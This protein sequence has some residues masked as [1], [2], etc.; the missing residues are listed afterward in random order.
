MPILLRICPSGSAHYL[1]T[2]R[3]KLRNPKEYQQILCTNPPQYAIL[4]SI[5]KRTLVP[6][7]TERKAYD[8]LLDSS[9]AFLLVF[10]VSRAKFGGEKSMLARVI[11]AILGTLVFIVHF[12][13][14]IWFNTEPVTISAAGKA[15]VYAA[16]IVL[17]IL[18]IILTLLSQ[19]PKKENEE[20]TEE[21]ENDT[22]ETA[23]AETNEGTAAK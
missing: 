22:E 13:V 18:M 16:P 21:S 5:N 23:T 10:F 7:Y 2:F 14:L 11:S 1:Q 15:V 4:I 6:T 3:D 12:G 8:W 19:P 9:I 20:E 17:S